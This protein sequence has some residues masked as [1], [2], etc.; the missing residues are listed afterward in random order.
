M[1]KDPTGEAVGRAV[2]EMTEEAVA[3][4]GVAFEVGGM[5]PGVEAVVASVYDRDAAI[6]R[7]MC[8]TL[9]RTGSSHHGRT[10]LTNSSYCRA[11]D[12]SLYH[13]SVHVV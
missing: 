12:P 9:Y 10:V 3:I 5:E 6:E 1:Y 2:F 4:R 7:D 13:D 11:N 8:R